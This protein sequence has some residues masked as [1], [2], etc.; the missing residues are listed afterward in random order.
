MADDPHPWVGT[1]ARTLRLACVVY[2]D[3]ER[4]T[5]LPHCDARVDPAAKVALDLAG[6]EVTWRWEPRE[7][8]W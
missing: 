2:G 5:F 8:G 7:G 4:F 3:V 1:S 6:A